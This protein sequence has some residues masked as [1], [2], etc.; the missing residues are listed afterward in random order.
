MAARTVPIVPAAP[1][2]AKDGALRVPDD[3][4]GRAGRLGAQVLALP[5]PVRHRLLRHGVHVGGATPKYDIA[6]FGAEF[7]RFSPRQADLLMVVGTIT[8]QA[9]ARSCAAVYEQ[10]CEPKWVI[11]FGVCA[12]TGGFYQNY[13]TMPGVDQVIP[14]DVYIPGCPPRPEKVLDGLMLL[15]DRIARDQPSDPARG[16]RLTRCRARERSLD[17]PAADDR[18]P[19]D[20]ERAPLSHGS[21][22][23]LRRSRPSRARARRACDAP[24]RRATFGFD[25]FLDV[26][27]VDW[28]GA[29]RRASTSCY[30]FYSTPPQAPRA[31]Q[32]AR[33]GGATRRVDS[34]AALYGSAR[35]MEREAT[36]C[37]ASRFEGN[38]DLR[39]ILLYEEFVGHPLR[40]DYPKEREQPLVPV[41]RLRLSADGRQLAAQ[42]GPHST[43]GSADCAS[44]SVVVNMGPSHPAM[45]GTVRI[46]AELDGEKVQRADVQCGYLHRG[47]EKEC[48]APHLAQADPVHRSP[49][50]RLADDQQ[51]RLRDGGREAAGHRDHAAR[52]V[53]PHADRRE[54]SRITDHLTCVAA[55]AM[56]LGAFTVFLYL[57]K[58]RD[59]IFELLSRALRRA[60]HRTRYVRIGGVARDL[61]DG[62]LDAPRGDPRPYE[63][64]VE[65]I[66]ELLDRNR[67]FLDRMRDV[68]VITHRRRARLRLHRPD[69]CAR[70]GWRYDVRKDAPYLVYAELD[71]DVPVGIEGD[72]YDRYVVRVERSTSRSH[73]MRQLRADAARRAGQ[74]RRSARHAAPKERASTT[75]S[76]R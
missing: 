35:F 68:G 1:H 56:E 41:P 45:H 74:R 24:A 8:A 67:I 31:A 59:C 27:A 50:L 37:T 36:T 55:P 17:V 6:R 73:M 75:R 32:D 49:Q 44:D 60:A 23:S 2:G 43:F 20:G 29:T 34:L 10:M 19:A 4:E 64:F 58:V 14:V 22:R 9:G 63:E 76:R 21:A 69:R 61:P 16:Q 25:L 5:V 33:A 46:V 71:F 53:H 13:A 66:H 7:P 72:N 54:F 28:P 57:V 65:R 11:A 12:S 62:W 18:A 47:F 15:Q 40:K 42:P 51:R 70:P 39:P 52:R 26:T 48:G 38:P 3:Q 30:H